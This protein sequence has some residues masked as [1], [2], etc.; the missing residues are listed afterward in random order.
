[1][2]NKNHLA[3]FFRQL[4]RDSQMMMDTRDI[5]DGLDTLNTLDTRH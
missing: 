1:M 3:R 2:E 4:A 5:I